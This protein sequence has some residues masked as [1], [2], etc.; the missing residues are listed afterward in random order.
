MYVL[1]SYSD[2]S[3]D[4][5][6]EN[7]LDMKEF[8]KALGFNYHQGPVSDFSSFSCQLKNTKIECIIAI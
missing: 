6:Y 8:N 3:Y 1:V 2:W 4:G 7:D 5:F